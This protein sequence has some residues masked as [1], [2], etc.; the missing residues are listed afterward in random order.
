MPLP[1]SLAPLTPWLRSPESLH[2]LLPQTQLEARLAGGDELR[3][4]Y[5]LGESFGGLVALELARRCGNKVDRIVL[6]N[7]VGTCC[8]AGQA[9]A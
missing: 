7:P 8:G 3:P 6:V 1:H 5:L 2:A 4:V 9:G